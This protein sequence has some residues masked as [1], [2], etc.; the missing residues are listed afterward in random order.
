MIMNRKPPTLAQPVTQVPLLDPQR[1]I[2]QMD[3]K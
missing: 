2:K 3:D 1:N